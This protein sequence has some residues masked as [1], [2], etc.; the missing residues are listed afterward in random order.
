MKF[1]RTQFIQKFISETRENLQALNDGILKLEKNPAELTAL[2]ELMRIIHTVKG[3]A[4]MLNIVPI[5]SV[6]HAFEEAL[7][8]IHKLRLSLQPTMADTLLQGVDLMG[9]ALG[10]LSSGQENAIPT[11]GIIDRLNQ[12]AGIQSA[13][14]A[15]V[16][17]NEEAKPES[18]ISVTEAPAVKKEKSIVFDKSAFVK[19]FL[20]EMTD[21]VLSMDQACQ[22][23]EVNKDDTTALEQGFRA[24]H[25]LKGSAR[26]LKFESASGIA[27]RIEM[28]FRSAWEKKT[29]WSGQQNEIVINTLDVLRQIQQRIEQAGQED[30]KQASILD[31]LDQAIAGQ[32]IDASAIRTSLSTSASVF[33]SE[34]VMEPSDEMDTADSLGERLIRAQWLTREQLLHVNQNSDNRL[35]LGERL[36]AFGYITREQLN[37]A[38]KEQR[39]SRELLGHTSIRRIQDFEMEQVS[40]PVKTKTVEDVPAIRVRLDKLDRLIKLVGELITAHMQS[41]QN[42]PA[43][44]KIQGELRRMTRATQDCYYRQNRLAGSPAGDSHE[45]EI[46]HAGQML[47]EQMESFGKHYRD[48]LAT[49][50]LLVND[51]QNS[52]MSMR[53]I[54]LS[55]IFD[56]YPR[57][58]RDLAK[59]LGKEIDLVIDGRDTELDRKMVEKLNEPLI[60]LIRNAIDHGIEPAEVRRANGKP[61]KGLLRINARNEG[62]SIVIEI[63]DDGRGLDFEKIRQKALAKGMVQDESDFHRMSENDII[64]MIFQPGFSTAD[65]ITDI[66]GRGY[67][68]DVVKQGVE[69]LKGYI[70]VFTRPNQGA[71]FTVHLPLTLT[72]LRALFVRAGVAQLA[73]PIASVSET[74]KVQKNDLIEVV[75]KKAIRLRNQLIPILPLVDVLKIDAVDE[76]DRDEFFVIVAHANGERAGFIVD[77]IT[78][79][80]DIIVKPLPG[81]FHRLRHISSATIA[82]NNDVIFVLHVPQLIEAIKETPVGE[83]PKAERKSAQSILVVD[84]SL[85]TREVEKTILQAYGYDVDTAKD[86]LEALGK[87]KQRAYDLV[88]T[89]LEMPVMDGFTLTT[90]IRE[91]KQFHQIPVVI[92]TSRDSADD[93]RR[94]IQVGANAYIV[95]GSFDQTNLIDTVE[96]LIG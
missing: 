49:F 67:G 78:D 92:V 22:R 2:P 70:S 74:L 80:K 85:N 58:V 35:P 69:N 87:M 10:A 56:A 8:S 42:L 11:A 14:V 88:V 21:H 72:S 79:E 71:I 64:N 81:H 68:M 57:A 31:L 39:A 45:D 34:S 65:F 29:E 94:G 28:L 91:E 9:T 96:S 93:K 83:K 32:T 30:F 40:A 44:R 4:K 77:D 95:K 76:S 6:A 75:R 19:R 26:M 89:D 82:G 61:E 60:H 59:N 7:L 90:R 20:T 84:D 51:I 48:S 62:T 16:S 54:A 63:A 12:C 66:S 53:M 13:G 47:T 27:Q 33:A 37:L 36:I 43:L 52:V 41:G 25:T 15:T 46:L 73:F 55:A 50:D 38:L 1:D 86:G 3:S 17:L 5:A 23:L 24:A 18:G